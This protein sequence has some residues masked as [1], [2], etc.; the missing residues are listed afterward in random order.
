MLR[1][2]T[3]SSYVMPADVPRYHYGC[4]TDTGIALQIGVTIGSCRLMCP[5]TTMAASQ[6]LVLHCKSV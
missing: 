6:I 2:P 1:K 5:V 3:G 4:V